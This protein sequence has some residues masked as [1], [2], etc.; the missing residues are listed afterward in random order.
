[1]RAR[2]SR[3]RNQARR[4]VAGSDKL[5]SISDEELLLKSREL[6]WRA[7]TGA[8]L[9]WLMP[10]AYMLV[11]EAARRT[12]GIV[13]YPVQVM[14]GIGLFEGGLIEMQTGEGKTLTALLPAYLRALPGYGCHVVT[15]NDYLAHRDAEEMGP[16]Y[17]AL[18]LTVGCI[19]TTSV[20][21]ERKGAYDKDITYG[22]AKEIGFD[23]LRDRLKLGARGG[24]KDYGELFGVETAEQEA[25][26]QRGHYFALIDEA[27]S[28]LI[29]EARTPLIIGVAMDQTPA[30]L[31]L[32]NWAEQVT[33][34]LEANK[35]YIYEPKYRTAYLTDFGC[36]RLLMVEKPSLLD[37]FDT[38]RINKH[39]EQALTARFGFQLNRD[40]IVNEEKIV[41]VD[42]STGRMMD[43]RTW[44]DGLHQAMEAKEGIPI[45]EMTGQAAKVTVQ[46]FFRQYAYLSG[47]TGTAMQS[48]REFRKAY[49]IRV[50]PIPTHRKCLRQGKPPRIFRTLDQKQQAVADEVER[51]IQKNCAVLVGTPSVAA[52][53]TLGALL[54]KRGINAPIINAKYHEQE[55]AI[56]V[57]AGQEARVTIATN[58]AGRGTDIKLTDA[59]RAAG[60]L[61][62]IA[63]EMHTSIRIDRQLVGRA[64]RQGDP[65]SYQFFLSLEDELL[66]VLEPE[67]REKMQQRAHPNQQGEISRSWIR[68]FRKVQR[69]L[70]KEHYKQRRDLCRQEHHQM[71]QHLLMGLDPYL[72]LTE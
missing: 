65:G 16:V 47:M 48:R 68:F 71:Q 9:K 12:L 24:Q 26:V 53:E 40:Y 2:V 52:S 64:A 59:A 1:M 8:P 72:E 33:K 5:Q 56:V 69:R 42:E 67:Y 61:H 30:T 35:D 14:G 58:M 22:T 57:E 17:N 43:G 10:E 21:F 60:G 18:G 55:A 15:V 31:A 28:I 46:T 3:W 29:D 4:I 36:R 54:K 7:K 51:L 45:T 39:V 50:A 11:R 27:D 63:T 19:Q 66:R 20:P 34:L 41:I 70:E 23:F 13:H 62:V 49:N 44:Q 32:Y 38:E 6:Q 25:L 37:T